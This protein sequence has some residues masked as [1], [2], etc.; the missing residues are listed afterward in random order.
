MEKIDMCWRIRST[1]CGDEP[2]D[3]PDHILQL[4]N[5]SKHFPGVQAL[6]QVNIAVRRGT[7]HALIGT[8]G[9]GK[10]TLT[11]IIA[12]VYLPSSGEIHFAGE[13]C[14]FHIPSDAQ[15]VGISTLY[16]ELTLLS[17]LTVAENV[18]LGS[19]PARPLIQWGDMFAYTASMLRQMRLDFRADT[20]VSALSIAQRQMVQII[21]ALKQ[22]A[23][24]IVMDEPTA[25]LTDYEAEE[26]FDVI[27]DLKEK[28]VTIIYITHRLEE[29]ER[30]CDYVTILRDGKVVDTRH[31]SDITT[32]TLADMMLGRPLLEH[33]PRRSPHIGEELLRV[34]GLTRY[35]TLEDVDL[36]LHSGEMLGITGIIGAGG[37]ALLH[38]IF[39]LDP[40]DEGQIYVN[41]RLVQIRSPQDAISYGIGLVS[42]NRQENGLLL[43]MGIVENINL[44][45]L[46]KVPPG[47]LIDHKHEAQLALHYVESLSIN[48]PYPDFK[49]R[50]LSGGNQQKVIV[51]KWM[52]TNPKILLCDEPTQGIDIGAKAELYRVMDDLTRH[53]A[54]LIMVSNDITEILNV[55]DRVLVMKHGQVICN[56]RCENTDR[57]TILSYM[58]S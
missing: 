9:A 25:R 50:H 55:C 34:Q 31:V 12:G 41:Y 57:Q 36:M 35:G 3:A 33:F 38:E 58:M 29:I 24:L 53:G 1:L 5:I 22:N 42:E 45:L 49:A 51:S 14:L 18:F 46:E 47:P 56:L 23:R 26:L 44:S 40:I 11:K 28:G 27:H 48:I 20:K 16:Q 21:K 4:R 30:H 39:G 13:T 52:A 8:N 32:R 54:G 10:S 2:L 17:D 7:I 37:T 19:E 43:D 6:A 15:A